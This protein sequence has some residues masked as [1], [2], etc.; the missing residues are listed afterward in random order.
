[1]L[2]GNELVV[3]ITPTL[4]QQ[5]GVERIVLMTASL[6][7]AKALNGRHYED[8]HIVPRSAS[9]VDVKAGTHVIECPSKILS[10]VP[11]GLLRRP[12]QMTTHGTDWLASSGYRRKNVVDT[13]SLIFCMSRY[14]GEDVS[15]IDQHLVAFMFILQ[16][17]IAD[18]RLSYVFSSNAASEP[19]RI[20]RTRWTQSS[21]FIWL[22]Q[23]SRSGRFI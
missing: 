20:I 13:I 16:R 19:I 15:N 14:G 22:S 17:R 1:M 3:T 10:G 12:T 6:S 9:F 8:G 23:V 18:G 2:T 5:N 7:D 11:L 4:S 21:Q